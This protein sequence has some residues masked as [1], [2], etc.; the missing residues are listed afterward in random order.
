MMTTASA[1]GVDIGKTA[2]AL[3]VGDG[4]TNLAQPFFALP[5]LGFCR[6]RARDIMGYSILLMLLQGPFYILILMLL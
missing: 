5:I 2:M 6:V 1:L 3:A 4:W